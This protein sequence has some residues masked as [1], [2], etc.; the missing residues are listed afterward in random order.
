M[1]LIIGPGV[2]FFF[3]LIFRG[4]LYLFMNDEL[5]LC[6]GKS[7]GFLV[8]FSLLLNSYSLSTFNNATIISLP[9]S[10][11]NP[12]SKLEFLVTALKD[13]YVWNLKNYFSIFFLVTILL[14]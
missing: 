8:I 3:I 9:F 5:M 13:E 11:L 10:F 2:F 7:V 1:E 6:S 14:Q 12:V 4:S